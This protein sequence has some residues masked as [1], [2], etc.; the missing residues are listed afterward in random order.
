MKLKRAK[1]TL[2]FKDLVEPFTAA[3]IAAAVGCALPT[4]YDW[5]SGRRKPVRYVR[6]QY[7]QMVREYVGNAQAMASADD[8]LYN[9]D[10]TL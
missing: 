3:Q 10:K 1:K 8:G 2:E 5:K 7:A 6:E 9:H 4:A